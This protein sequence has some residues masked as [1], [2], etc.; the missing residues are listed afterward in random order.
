MFV[1]WLSFS[2][3][4]EGSLCQ[5]AQ[6][7]AQQ[8]TLNAV[9][10]NKVNE[11]KVNFVIRMQFHLN[12]SHRWS[13]AR[14]KA[15]GGEGL[16]TRYK[17]KQNGGIVRR[18]SST[19]DLKIHLNKLISDKFSDRVAGTVKRKRSHNIML[20]LEN[21]PLWFF[22]FFILRYFFSFVTFPQAGECTSFGYKWKR[23]RDPDTKKKV[24]WYRCFV[25]VVRFGMV[26]FRFDIGESSF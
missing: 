7:K 6:Q 4:L 19:F 3:R 26:W 24:F 22:P 25:F 2:Q 8:Q 12:P 5:L 14:H 23:S 18:P 16:I 20:Q 1:W 17:I 11:N 21:L 13:W 9:T 10:I 15:G